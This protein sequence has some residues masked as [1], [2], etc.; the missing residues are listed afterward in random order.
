MPLTPDRA[1]ST[2]P[3]VPITYCQPNQHSPRVAA[4]LRNLSKARKALKR[5]RQL[6]LKQ[7]RKNKR[8]VAMFPDRSSQIV[9]V[10]PVH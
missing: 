2:P 3:D 10:P 5:R 6:K 8:P 1:R 7:Q 4:A 9:I